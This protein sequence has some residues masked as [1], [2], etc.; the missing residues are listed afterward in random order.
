M[1]FVKRLCRLIGEHSDAAPMPEKHTL[2]QFTDQYLGD[3]GVLVLRI[4]AANSNDVTV[5]DLTSVMWNKS[6]KFPLL[7]AL[8]DYYHN[9][10]Y[11]RR[12]S[13]S[14]YYYHCHYHHY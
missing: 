11:Y 13:Y 14:Y 5:G 2:K 3:D 1:T 8:W 10:Y 6:V 4:L 9:Y 12:S 7:S